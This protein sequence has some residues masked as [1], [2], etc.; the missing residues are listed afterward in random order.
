VR[1]RGDGRSATLTRAPEAT[2]RAGL[3]LR[4]SRLPECAR[5]PAPP[6]GLRPRTAALPQARSL[7][8]PCPGTTRW[9]CAQ[10]HACIRACSA[11][12]CSA[13]QHEGLLI[14]RWARKPFV[15]VQIQIR[16][17]LCR[18]ASRAVR[19]RAC[20]AHRRQPPLRTVLVSSAPSA[21]AGARRARRSSGPP[22]TSCRPSPGR[23]Q[24]RRRR[25]AHAPL[26]RP[27]PWALRRCP[28][29][30]ASALHACTAVLHTCARS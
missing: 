25:C 7:C 9:R 20:A 6:A 3:R 1:A 10:L 28:Q 23:A 26:S 15:S 14:Q 2:P 30:H 13:H 22:S 4:L 12:C 8:A 27:D 5:L 24:T 19:I 18:R 16:L 29:Q 11:W 21:P 17:A